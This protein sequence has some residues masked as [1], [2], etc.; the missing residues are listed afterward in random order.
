MCHKV[1]SDSYPR[2][3]PTCPS[4]VPTDES[5]DNHG[6]R[7]RVASGGS[8]AMQRPYSNRGAAVPLAAAMGAAG[9]AKPGLN[10]G[11]GNAGGG[12]T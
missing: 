4:D 1:P 10:A 2:Q 12:G 5:C 6:D 9:S 11:R 3:S 7:F 8:Q